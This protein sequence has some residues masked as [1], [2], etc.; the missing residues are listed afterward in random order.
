M[1]PA[2]TLD[3]LLDGQDLGEDLAA[4]LLVALT[5]PG[6]APAMAGAVLA[7]LR[8]KGETAA[9]V[10]GF[11]RA[12]R[13]LARRPD[14]PG[15]L[16]CV[17]TVGT[18]GDGSGSLNLSTGSALLAA[19]CGVPVVK[20]G[21]RSISS[22]SGSAD[23][24]ESLGLELPADAAECGACL[25]ECGF[26]FLFAPHFHPAM[27]ALAPVRA[28]LGVRTVFNLLGP[29]T[30]PVAPPFQVIGA[31]S[32]AAARLMADCLAGL[33]VERA[34]VVHGEPGWDEPT[35]VGRFLLLDVRPGAVREEQRDPAGYGLARCAPEALAG[36]DCAHNAERLFAVLTGDERGPHRDALL[37]GAALA[38][39]VSGRAEAAEQGIAM[40]AA[41]ID[42]GRAHALIL[43]LRHFFARPR[44]AHAGK[45]A[46]TGDL[47]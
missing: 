25:R 6:L 8:A 35:P 1:S 37:L 44:Q 45:P 4:E 17:D 24:L 26:V 33:P 12:M 43:K 34:F 16:A 14:V 46:R 38:L 15:D 10:R 41:A 40:A 23:V 9:E 47:Q 42:D 21:N 32:P 22:R 27:K 18:G 13:K 20:H 28:A 39:E 3:R 7:A 29:L 5:D 19:A 2:Q 30:N 36:G 11:A 31:Y